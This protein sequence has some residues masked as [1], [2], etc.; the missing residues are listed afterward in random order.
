MSVAA[1]HLCDTHNVSKLKIQIRNEAFL[2]R[3]SINIERKRK[4]SIDDV[5]LLRLALTEIPEENEQLLHFFDNRNWDEFSK[6]LELLVT[7]NP[8]FT[9][10]IIGKVMQQVKQM[11]SLSVILRNCLFDSLN[12]QSKLSV[13][14]LNTLPDEELEDLQ[15]NELQA[16]LHI[17]PLNVNLTDE[18]FKRKH[19]LSELILF[20]LPALDSVPNTLKIVYLLDKLYYSSTVHFD[21]SE[22]LLL[23]QKLHKIVLNEECNS[24]RNVIHNLI[25]TLN[26]TDSTNM[27]Q[28]FANC[29]SPLNVL[30]KHDLLNLVFASWDIQMLDELSTLLSEYTKDNELMIWFARNTSEFGEILAFQTKMNCKSSFSQTPVMGSLPSNDLVNFLFPSEL[31]PEYLSLLKDIVIETQTSLF[32]IQR[33]NS[34]DNEEF[35]EMQQVYV[36]SSVLSLNDCKLR[37]KLLESRLSEAQWRYVVIE[38]TFVKQHNDKELHIA[39]SVCESSANESD[40]FEKK[41]GIDNFTSNDECI[42]TQEREVF[43]SVIPCM[44][45]SPDQLLRYCL[46]ERKIDKAKEVYKLFVDSLKNTE[47]AF[48]LLVIEKYQDLSSKLKLLTKKKCSSTALS[49]I[50]ETA[51]KGLQR[52]EVQALLH[53]FYLLINSETDG[54]IDSNRLAVDF[55]LTSSPSLCLSQ[56]ILESSS[57]SCPSE[58]ERDNVVNDKLRSFMSNLSSVITSALNSELQSKEDLGYLLSSSL[59]DIFSEPSSQRIEYENISKIKSS[60]LILK[61]QL[62]SGQSVVSPCDSQSIPDTRKVLTEYQKLIRMSPIGKN[63]YLNALFLHIRKV[64]KALNECKKRS[65]SFTK[66]DLSISEPVNFGLKPLGGTSFSVLYDSPAVTLCSMILKHGINPKIV[67][68]LA[69]DMRVDL[70]ETLCSLYSPRIPTV[71]RDDLDFELVDSCHP[72]LCELIHC[73][74][75]GSQS[76]NNSVFV[77]NHFDDDSES[78]KSD[79][80]EKM[81]NKEL[82]DYFRTK[83]WILVEIL[84]LLKLL[85]SGISLKEEREC[86]L[87]SDSPLCSWISFINNF[88]NC[89]SSE[90]P[91]MIKA[92]ALHPKIPASHTTAMK[93]LEKLAQNKDLVKM[94]E[95]LRIVDMKNASSSLISLRTAVLSKLTIDTQNIKFALQVDDF[96]TKCDLIHNTLLTSDSYCDAN[97]TLRALKSVSFLFNSLQ[98]SK[99]ATTVA[100]AELKL[101]VDKVTCFTKIAELAGLRSWRDSMNDLPH[102]DILLILKTR[103]AYNLLLEWNEL[104]PKNENCDIETEELRLELLSLAYCERKQF[105]QLDNIFKISSC[106][107]ALAEKI[108]PQIEDW[109]AKFYVISFLLNNET[110]KRNSDKFL[111][112]KKYF[113]GI[114]L[115][116]TLPPSRRLLY[117]PVCTQPSLVIEQMLMNLDFDSLEKCIKNLQFSELNE[118]LEKYA[119]KAVDIE[120]VDNVSLA[121]SDTT[122]I[123][124][125]FLM[126]TSSTGFVMPAVVPTIEQWIPDS[127]VSFCMNC[128]VERFSMFNRRHH[129]RRCG[130]VIC[131]ACSRNSLVIPE[132]SP[133]APVRVCDD[134]F[135]QTKVRNPRKESMSSLSSSSKVVQWVLTLNEQQNDVVREEFFY[136][137]APSSSLCLSILKLHTNNKKCAEV[138]VDK[139]C[140]PLFEI[141]SSNQVDYGLIINTIKSLLLSAKVLVGDDDSKLLNKI[142]VLLAR[143]D[144]VKMLVNENCVDTSLISCVVNDENALLKLQEKLIEMERFELA[145]N[146]AMK[147]SINLKPIWKTWAMVCLKNLRFLEARTKYKYCFTSRTSSETNTNNSKLLEEIFDTLERLI[148]K[149][150]ELSVR[151]K[152]KLIKSGKLATKE[153]SKTPQRSLVMEEAFYYL[154]NYGCKEDVVKFHLRF[155]NYKKAMET[156]IAETSSSSLVSIFISAFLIPS[157]NKGCLKK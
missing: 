11:R 157:L 45:A 148:Y 14:L 141:L 84:D 57:N 105:V 46:I 113:T 101:L 154:E 151:E 72:A 35:P 138:I 149:S 143:L 131:A 126:E 144:I 102:V 108:L 139:F 33:S 42:L 50:A 117:T 66:E 80:E 145:L 67:D 52:S 71:V 53:E 37:L 79:F 88:L 120:I 107:I 39:D 142:N 1:S 89:G 78:P 91:V 130:R 18:D 116:N 54:V 15:S 60:V 75:V 83:S 44:L 63:S 4:K 73:Y 104:R 32:T 98:P 95:V 133:V 47:E 5:L 8:Y 135:T 111:Y 22:Y 41:S 155:D 127:R 136:E 13:H 19:F 74:L 30:H 122:M 56:I 69:R 150:V 129:C 118:L 40:E 81:K 6:K 140:R 112:Y 100:S 152:C 3:M 64:S 51:A 96:K 109:D 134:C 85:K 17:F 87:R 21:P 121:D 24:N 86:S 38:P 137:S 119:K 26:W 114:E 49:R 59:E 28:S 93:V 132:F 9:E 20:D 48:E 94:Y 12:N 36:S 147:F 65:E 128:K 68:D 124:S 82:I 106:S 27:F 76:K 25:Q 146:I 99:H 123:S 58:T 16:V 62:F 156:F 110:I 55:A 29:D 43:S 115:I 10:F 125:S 103:K 77:Q 97:T 23:M 31:V 34:T 92:L 7:E 61:Q 153:D 90:D 70:I 2:N